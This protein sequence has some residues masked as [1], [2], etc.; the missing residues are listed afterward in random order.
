MQAATGNNQQA[1]RHGAADLAS[2]GVVGMQS[3]LPFRQGLHFRA[4]SNSD[5]KSHR[6]S[7]NRLAIYHAALSRKKRDI[8]SNALVNR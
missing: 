8:L 7:Q 6:C 4:A 5:E 1:E 3:W 2:V